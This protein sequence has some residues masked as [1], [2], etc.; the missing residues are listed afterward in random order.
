MVSRVSCILGI[1]WRSTTGLFVRDAETQVRKAINF[2]AVLL[3]VGLLVTGELTFGKA[4]SP[5]LFRLWWILPLAF[6]LAS[7]IILT[8][9]VVLGGILARRVPE[10]FL[11]ALYLA[12]CPL[13]AILGLPF[14]LPPVSAPPEW[15]ELAAPGLLLTLACLHYRSL[16]YSE[17]EGAASNIDGFK[18]AR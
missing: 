11:S 2:P 8:T 5:H 14:S 13:L 10:R 9:S 18:A 4:I 15:V 12:C 3:G 17:E 16:K 7:L 1:D 6:A